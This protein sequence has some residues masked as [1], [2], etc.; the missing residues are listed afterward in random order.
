MLQL[1]Y[2]TTAGRDYTTPGFQF[3]LSLSCF[4]RGLGSYYCHGGSSQTIDVSLH[5]NGQHMT[6]AYELNSSD[7]DDNVS[8]G[9][10]LQLEVGDQVYL[11]LA[12]NA[13]IWGN[14]YNPSTFHGMLLFTV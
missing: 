3:L 14:S 8:N 11:H 9:V 4:G 6:V 12:A 13:H 5:K 2:Y 7:S 1:H 10:S